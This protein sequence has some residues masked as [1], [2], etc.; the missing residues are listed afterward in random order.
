MYHVVD[1][2]YTSL[3]DPIS[4]YLTDKSIPEDLFILHSRRQESLVIGLGQYCIFV[5]I[6]E[7]LDTLLFQCFKTT[8]E[9]KHY[10]IISYDSFPN[11]RELLVSEKKII[12]DFV[13]I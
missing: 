5:T 4:R 13:I 7:F 10:F 12:N 1:V 8:L 3:N 9:I 11:V 6:S 2:P